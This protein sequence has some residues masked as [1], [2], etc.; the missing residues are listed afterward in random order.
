M[1]LSSIGL[2]SH[3]ILIA[4]VELVS[5]IAFKNQMNAVQVVLLL[6][7]GLSPFKNKNIEP[8]TTILVKLKVNVT[9][10]ISY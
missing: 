10:L 4:R 6:G 9:S 1:W 2:F 3:T 7:V 8:L 5:K